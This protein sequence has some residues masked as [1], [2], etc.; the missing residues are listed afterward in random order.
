MSD[1]SITDLIARLRYQDKPSNPLHD[2]DLEVI[3]NEAADALEAADE[4]LSVEGQ[5]LAQASIHTAA[6]TNGAL[7]GVGETLAKM[8]CAG[9]RA[10]R[11]AL[12]EQVAALQ[13]VIAD[14][15]H[16]TKRG[17]IATPPHVIAALTQSPVDALEAVKEK[18]WDEGY[19][20]GSGDEAHYARG[21]ST[22]PGASDHPHENPYHTKTE[23]EKP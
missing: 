16:Q 23:G 1:V 8:G 14:A 20:A 2:A 4:A 7:R 22:D 11:D 10:E 3:M 9:L 6:V 21:L 17:N 15:L 12:T 5:Q 13:A 18:A 19:E